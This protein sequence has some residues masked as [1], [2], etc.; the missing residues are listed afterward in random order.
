M[1]LIMWMLNCELTAMMKQWCLCLSDLLSD[2]P[3]LLSGHRS[4]SVTEHL[5]WSVLSQVN[6]SCYIKSS[7][8]SNR[9]ILGSICYFPGKCSPFSKSLISLLPLFSLSSLSGPQFD[10]RHLLRFSCIWRRLQR[11]RNLR[12]DLRH[13]LLCHLHDGVGQAVPNGQ[14]GLERES[15]TSYHVILQQCAVC[16]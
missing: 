2:L 11:L 7:A 10:C 3:W 13:G 5:R 1:L 15:S 16:A 12:D 9:R 14:L 8:K 4:F 6:C